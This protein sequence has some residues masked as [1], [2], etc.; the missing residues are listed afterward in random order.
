MHVLGSFYHQS[1]YTKVS[2][3]INLALLLEESNGF[4]KLCNTCCFNP[5]P[6]SNRR[7]RNAPGWMRS[8]S[9]QV[10][11]LRSMSRCAFA[12]WT[13]A[14]HRRKVYKHQLAS[15]GYY[16]ISAH[17]NKDAVFLIDQVS[18]AKVGKI[19]QRLVQTSCYHLK[20]WF[21]TWG[22]IAIFLEVARASDKN[23]HISTFYISYMEPLFVVAKITASPGKMIAYFFIKNCFKCDFDHYS[24]LLLC[25]AT[26]E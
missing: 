14:L 7:L 24:R 4:E 8:L 25:L 1:L 9:R 3:N 16:I 26:H 15:Y 23:I 5:F 17:H 21:S 6:R 2:W 22:S 18:P 20:Q 19:K 11:S 10:H 13:S 12:M